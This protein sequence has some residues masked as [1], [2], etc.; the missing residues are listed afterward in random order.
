MQNFSCTLGY[1][2][3]MFNSTTA[4]YI[5]ND[6]LDIPNGFQVF[7]AFLVSILPHALN[8]LF[9]NNFIDFWL[10]WV[11]AAVRGLFSSFGEWRLLFVA[12][13]RLLVAAAFLVAKHGLYSTPP[14]VVPVPEL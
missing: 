11:F 7:S 8:L 5:V 9:K 10:C 12:V 14:S 2:S 1:Y 13:S 3:D 4:L 6:S